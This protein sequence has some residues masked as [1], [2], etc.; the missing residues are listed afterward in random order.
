MH[1]ST[2]SIKKDIGTYF[3]VY[4]TCCL[5]RILKGLNWLRV[6]YVLVVNVKELTND[7]IQKTNIF[8]IRRITTANQFTTEFYELKVAM[9]VYSYRF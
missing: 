1:I 3:T 2:L 8:R 4:I 7:C 6:M 5:G 9:Y